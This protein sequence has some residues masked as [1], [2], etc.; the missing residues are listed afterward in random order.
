MTCGTR[1]SRRL[2]R[3]V[4]VEDAAPG[5][6]DLRERRVHAQHVVER[7]LR[8]GIEEARLG[9]GGLVERRGRGSCRTRSTCRGRRNACILHATRRCARSRLAA[10]CVR[11]SGASRYL[12]GTAYQAPWMQISG[13]DASTTRAAAAGSTRSASWIV[14]SFA[15]AV[16][17]RRARP[18]A[19]HRVHLGAAREQRPRDLSADE[20]AGTGQEDAHVSGA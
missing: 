18:V 2:H 15:T 10:T 12:P 14:S 8:G 16:E 11:F 19:D 7:E 6:A 17:P 5:E 20:A 4:L 3:P 9:R 13:F 1:R